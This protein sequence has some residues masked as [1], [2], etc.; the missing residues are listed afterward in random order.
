MDNPIARESI[1]HGKDPEYF[2]IQNEDMAMRKAVQDARNS[3]G[4]FVAAI[5][6]RTAAQRGF[7]VKKPFVQGTE[8][9]Y[10]WLSDVTFSGNRFHGKVDNHPVKITSLKM[11]EKVSVNPD[12]ISDWAYVDHG[13]LVG[14]YTIRVLYKELS[15]K[16]RK[17]L[18]NESRFHITK[19]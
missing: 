15:P 17:E 5:Q 9:E 1:R 18:E 14:G 11:G 16:R 19:Q 12:E 13:Y 7:E 10:I 8:V 6:H 2:R 4:T 3:V